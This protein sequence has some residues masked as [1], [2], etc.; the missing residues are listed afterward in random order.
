M[1]DDRITVFVAP[2]RIDRG[3]QRLGVMGKQ[4]NSYARHN[5]FQLWREAPVIATH[6]VEKDNGIHGS[7][8]QSSFGLAN[9]ARRQ[10]LKIG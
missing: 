7:R 2:Y 8:K 10:H 1:G 4:E 3:G 5:S 9:I 6:I